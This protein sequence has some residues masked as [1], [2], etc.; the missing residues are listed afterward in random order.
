MT[1]ALVLGAGKI[2]VGVAE[3]LRECGD[4]RV[5]LADSD[6]DALESW[7]RGNV[8]GER[9]DV[10]DKDALARVVDAADIVISALPY[11]LDPL[12]GEAARECGAHFF[13]LTEDLDTARRLREIA[14]EAETVFVPQC[15]LA[16]GFISIVANHLVNRLRR[17]P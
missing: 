10:T 9:I 7:G 14:E 4:Y 1:K 16:P 8:K 13:N 15:G 2:G 11:F 17:A 5:T 12:V 6:T 3:I